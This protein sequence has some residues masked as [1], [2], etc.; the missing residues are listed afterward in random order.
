MGSIIIGNIC[1]LLAAISDSISGS[2]EKPK[3]VLGVQIISQFFY[4]T[5]AIVLKGYSALVQNV[6]A[7]FRNLLAMSDRKIKALEWALTIAAVVFGFYFNNRGMIGW[8]PVIANFE[9]TVC[10]FRFSDEERKLKIAF[11]INMVLFTIFNI[12]IL[13]IV[14]AVTNAAVAITIVVFLVKSKKTDNPNEEQETGDRNEK[15]EK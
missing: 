2:R 3:Q 6:V 12:A 5:S 10:V 13:N 15:N 11:M 14:G 8:L 9:Y 4:A 7:V 1:S